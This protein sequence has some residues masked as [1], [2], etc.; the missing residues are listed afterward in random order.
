M[1]MY[2][3][4]F[5]LSSKRSFINPQYLILQTSF[6][7]HFKTDLP[8]FEFVFGRVTVTMI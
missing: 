7:T 5:S 3:A 6:Y 8:N 1:R 4:H 2:Q